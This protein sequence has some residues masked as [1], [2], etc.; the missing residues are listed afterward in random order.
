MAEIYYP[1]EKAGLQGVIPGVD[2]I[3]YSTMCEATFR[4]T[5]ATGTGLKS[6]KKQW[7]TPVILTTEGIAYVETV[8]YQS[9]DMDVR[10]I[11]GTPRYV[12]WY[13]VKW[14]MRG[15]FQI[16]DTEFKLIRTAELETEEAFSRR[17][18]AFGGK[19][20]PL[21][22]R[23]KGE[24]GVAHK[25]VKIFLWGLGIGALLFFIAFFAFGYPLESLL[26][27]YYWG[28]EF[29][30]FFI[31][32][33]LIGLGIAWIVISR[34]ASRRIQKYEESKNLPSTMDWEEIND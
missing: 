9:Y 6:F 27:S 21:L 18:H 20:R 17:F 5:K 30:W 32:T 8:A 1:L 25:G 26:S 15:R 14:V 22:K 24:A 13:Y 34:R 31:F 16:R 33:F 23:V 2:Q 4:R 19:F 10:E 29:L 7:Q 3:L 28:S 11:P 12:P